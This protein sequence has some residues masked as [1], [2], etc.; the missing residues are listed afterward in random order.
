MEFPGITGESSSIDSFMVQAWLHGSFDN[1]I[2]SILGNGDIVTVSRS[3][4]LDL[5]CGAAGA[6]GSLG[7]MT[8]I[9]L[10]LIEAK[11]FVKTT[12]FSEAKCGRR[13]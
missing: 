11:K 5:F 1:T 3:E 12:L 8:L 6:V 10:Q 13:D 2:K 4:N 7:I 9:K